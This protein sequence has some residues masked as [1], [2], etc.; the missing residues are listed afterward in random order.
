VSNENTGTLNE[1]ADRFAAAGM[2]CDRT[3][4]VPVPAAKLEMRIPFSVPVKCA[5]FRMLS[6]HFV[7]ILLDCDL[8]DPMLAAVERELHRLTDSWSFCGSVHLRKALEHCLK[9]MPSE[10]MRMIPGAY[11][12][13]RLCDIE[14][15]KA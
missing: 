5:D 7:R 12:V 4:H 2:A 1:I 8:T 3:F 6:Q 10:R 9:S 13:E 11:R 14:Q 15:H